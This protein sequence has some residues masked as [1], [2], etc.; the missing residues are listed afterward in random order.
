[1]VSQLAAYRGGGGREVKQPL[2]P[3]G[4][5]VRGVSDQVGGCTGDEGCG[6]RLAKE[7]R[8]GDGVEA[9]RFRPADGMLRPEL[10]GIGRIVTDVILGS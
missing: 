8:P 3:A 2:G 5:R 7:L 9:E 1:M 4:E 6:G 10:A